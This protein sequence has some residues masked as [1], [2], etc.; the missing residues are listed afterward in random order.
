MLSLGPN[1]AA[2][3]FRHSLTS[4]TSKGFDIQDSRFSVREKQ[5]YC[6]INFRSVQYRQP[7]LSCFSDRSSLSDAT[8]SSPVYVRSTIQ[9]IRGSQQISGTAGSA[10]SRLSRFL[11]VQVH[12]NPF[13][14]VEPLT[15]SLL[16]SGPATGM[17]GKCGRCRSPFLAPRQKSR[18]LWLILAD[19][20][21]S[22]REV[23]E[24]G[25]CCL[26]FWGSLEIDGRDGTGDF[27][28][29]LCFSVA[30]VFSCSVLVVRGF[31]REGV[32]GL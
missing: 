10:G 7:L 28:L 1:G 5:R 14:E 11:Y 16:H 12:G 6:H 21:H 29:C 2:T 26:L 30:C 9:M 18:S 24:E 25:L 15:V 3:I 4:L 8:A 31:M 32:G 22:T 20:S 27:C 13:G 23:A 19:W 17:G